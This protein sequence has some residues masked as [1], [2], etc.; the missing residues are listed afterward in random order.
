MDRGVVDVLVRLGYLGGQDGL[1]QAAQQLDLPFL[2]CLP[3]YLGLVFKIQ[4]N[5]PDGVGIH[6]LHEVSDVSSDEQMIKSLVSLEER[7]GLIILFAVC[8]FG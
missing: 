6:E 2:E 7:F 3:V 8:V 1:D 5:K 4:V